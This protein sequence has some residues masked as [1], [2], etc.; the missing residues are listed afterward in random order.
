M[1]LGAAGFA[2]KIEIDTAHF[3]GNYPDRC[4]IQAAHLTT[5]RQMRL[6]C[7]PARA[8]IS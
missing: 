2:K 5:G 1:A 4:S 8:G 6:F 3:K 7:H